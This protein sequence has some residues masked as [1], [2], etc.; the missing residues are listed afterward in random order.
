MRSEG[1][2]PS[3]LACNL[4]RSID[5]H[6]AILLRWAGVARKDERSLAWKKWRSDEEAQKIET[7]H[8]EKKRGASG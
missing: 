4:A 1:T 7:T 2:A 8:D 5:G 6:T 3:R